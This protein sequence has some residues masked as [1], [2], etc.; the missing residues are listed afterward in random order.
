MRTD[1]RNTMLAVLAAFALLLAPAAAAQAKKPLKRGSHGAR[2]EQVQRWLGLTPDGIYGPATKRAV[3]RF[4]RRRGLTVDGI[5]GP[6]TWRAL[7]R[8]A[9]ARHA[10]SHGGRI[11]RHAAVRQLQRALGIT[12]D[13]IFGPATKAA[14]KRFQRAHG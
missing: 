6:A 12:A 13:G 14:V 3:K 10:S 2:V 5:V 9:H 8:A 11:G 1:R 4:Q 7:R